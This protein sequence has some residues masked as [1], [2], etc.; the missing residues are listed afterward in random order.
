MV[1]QHL[2]NYFKAYRALSEEEKANTP[3]VNCCEYLVKAGS[4][5]CDF[6]FGKDVHQIAKGFGGGMKIE[7]VCGALTGSV[8]VLTKL[9]ADQEDFDEII[10][11]FF[12]RFEKQYGSIQCDD[13]KLKYRNDD[14]GCQD[15]MKYAG[16]IL[17]EM[18]KE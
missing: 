4:K 8:M 9:Y 15:V 11:S 18:I 13:L 2:D 17:E 1:V 12:S 6:T 5:A 10:Q 3:H 14:I 16:E 7:S